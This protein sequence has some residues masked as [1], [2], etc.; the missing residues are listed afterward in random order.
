MEEGSVVTEYRYYTKGGSTFGGKW[1]GQIVLGRI[2]FSNGDIYIGEMDGETPHG[3]GKFIYTGY[4]EEGD[5]D[6]GEFVTNKTDID[7][8]VA[9]AQ[10]AF[11]LALKKQTEEVKRP[12]E[13]KNEDIKDT[14]IISLRPG[15]MTT[16][17]K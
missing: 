6:L 17:K 10:E 3:K 15:W 2:E 11:D 8:I 9:A 14:P 1:I 13:A 4:V 5:W 12:T 7:L 16:E